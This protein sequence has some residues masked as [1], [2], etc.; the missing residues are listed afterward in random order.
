MINQT[1][2]EKTFVLLLFLFCFVDNASIALVDDGWALIF[3][4]LVFDI[5]DMVHRLT[6]G[7][8]D[9]EAINLA[10]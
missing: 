2:V 8:S 4:D 3:V 10:A 7:G 6:D 5:L 1:F 9:S